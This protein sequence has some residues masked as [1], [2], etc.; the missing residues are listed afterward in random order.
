MSSREGFLLASLW[1]AIRILRNRPSGRI[2]RRATEAGLG[3][4]V[5]IGIF[6]SFDRGLAQL[7]AIGAPARSSSGADRGSASPASRGSSRWSDSDRSRGRFSLTRYVDNLRFILDVSGQFAYGWTR[8]SIVLKAGGLAITVAAMVL[9]WRV[10]R[11]DRDA[12]HRFV[13]SMIALLCAVVLRVVAYRADIWHYPAMLW[14]PLLALVFAHARCQP[15]PER[16]RR[17]RQCPGLPSGP[18]RDG[19]E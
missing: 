17:H 16:Y 9:M 6:R 19:H 11:R 2:A 5:A 15:R 3:I 12:P 13:A 7:V 18:L 14:A 10:A 4:T 1:L 8:E